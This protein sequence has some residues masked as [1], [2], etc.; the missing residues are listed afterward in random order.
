[1][2]TEK[3][4]KVPSIYDKNASAFNRFSSSL[5]AL[6]TTLINSAATRIRLAHLHQDHFWLLAFCACS[7]SLSSERHAVSSSS[8]CE[9]RPNETLLHPLFATL[10]LLTHIYSYIIDYCCRFW[11]CL[12]VAHCRIYLE[13]LIATFFEESLD[14][15]HNHGGI[16]VRS[17]LCKTAITRASAAAFTFASASFSGLS[18][19]LSWPRHGRCY[20]LTWETIVKVYSVSLLQNYLFLY[21]NPSDHSEKIIYNI[22][23]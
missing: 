3:S 16:W 8:W 2:P 4:R 22:I 18:F 15:A 11:S 21:R 1:M 20:L 12:V 13:M 23:Q 5:I 9:M 19:S 10:C 6:L 7:R 17:A 14:I